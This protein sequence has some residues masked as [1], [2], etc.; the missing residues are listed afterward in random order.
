MGRLWRDEANDYRGHREEDG[1]AV[2]C[3]GTPTS[4]DVLTGKVEEEGGGMP[5]REYWEKWK[6]REGTWTHDDVLPSITLDANGGEICSYLKR[7]PCKVRP[8]T[9]MQDIMSCRHNITC[10]SLMQKCSKI[11]A[12]LHTNGLSRSFSSDDF[13]LSTDTFHSEFK[14]IALDWLQRLAGHTIFDGS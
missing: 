1:R 4:V 5:I 14:D 8:R 3:R 10:I 9:L 11:N 12:L 13:I 2:R 7:K 6:E